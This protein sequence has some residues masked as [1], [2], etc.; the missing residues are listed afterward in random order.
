MSNDWHATTAAQ[1][2]A[3][4]K[5]RGDAYLDPA[6]LEG[7]GD[8]HVRARALVQGIIAGLHR[9]PHRGGSVEFAEYIEYAP[10]HEIRHIDWRVYGK[11]D[12]YVV[13]QFEDETNL[14]AYMLMD[15]SGS[16]DFRGESAGVTKLRYASFMAASLA[17]LFLKQGDAVGAMS[18]DDDVR[19]YLPASAKRSHLDDLFFMLD[20]LPSRRGT[21]LTQALRTIAERARTRSLLMVFS[22]LIAS[23]E[24]QVMQM[25]RVLR[26]R[27]YEVALFHV[28]DRDEIELPYE[29]LTLFEGLEEGEGELL[30]DPDDVRDRYRQMMRDR[31]DRIERQCAEGDIE[32]VRCVTDESI[33]QAALR[34]LRPRR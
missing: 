28:L 7:M 27:R 30:V 2:G 16:M 21:S 3:A 20:E 34:F 9:S 22:D 12:R 17:Y 1:E 31:L 11:S 33:E 14:R 10:G 8:M 32:Y 6:T 23:D 18:F 15:G 26:S 19:H 4:S 13:K 25:L 5:T 29:G 24:E